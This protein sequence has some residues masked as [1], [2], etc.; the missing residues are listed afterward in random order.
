MVGKSKFARYLS[1]VLPYEASK[2]FDFD[3]HT[4]F[5]ALEESKEEFIDSMI[6]M[7]L[8][9]HHDIELDRLTL[10]S[11]FENPLSDSILDKIISVKTYVE[12]IMQ[13]VTIYD[14]IKNPT[15]IYK[16][17]LEYSKSIGKHVKKKV[18][19]GGEERE[20]YDGYHQYNDKF[21]IVVTDHI[22]L[23]QSEYSNQKQKT[24]TGR[25]TMSLWNDNYCSII[26]NKWGWITLNVQQTAMSSDD[27]T[28]FKAKRLEPELSDAGDNKTI[29]RSDKVIFSL[30]DPS[31]YGLK[32]DGYID[33]SKYPD[34]YRKLKILKN[35]YGLSNRSVPLF[36]EGASGR[37]SEL[38]KQ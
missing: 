25:E 2:E 29:L 6:L 7:M 35:R 8:K 12:D 30:F 18:D 16:A 27:V 9:I 1:I 15:G 26:S 22:S 14:D 33:L 38:E 4:L 23:L 17:C 36:F 21:V 10:N 5:F 19:F 24:L 11:Y 20:I 28:H 32:K 34:S 3:F 31:R 37:F 13:H